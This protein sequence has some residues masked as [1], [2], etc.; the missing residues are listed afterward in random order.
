LKLPKKFSPDELKNWARDFGG[1]RSGWHS[2][3]RRKK[4]P[5]RM[6]F[7]DLSPDFAQAT[8]ALAGIYDPKFI[9]R[10][11]FG[12]AYSLF[13]FSDK[14][15]KIETALTALVCATYLRE[16]GI[17][18]GDR[19]GMASSVEMRLP[20]V[21]YKFVET[22]VGLRK[23]RSDA[24]LSPKQ[25]LKDAVG[26]VLPASILNRP[27]RGFAPPTREWHD[28]LFARYGDSLHGGFLVEAEILSGDGAEKLSKGEFPAGTF[29]P[30]SFKALV[31]EQWCRQMLRI[32]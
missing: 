30:L 21:D 29:S 4:N 31:L 15:D 7:Y 5:E 1:M 8:N 22:I 28:A 12:D 20:L 10:I 18:Q 13:N 24:N 9:D 19:L 23:T 17:A 25:W 14:F 3:K 32:C 26:D 11:E 2:L 27:K 6:I 16:N